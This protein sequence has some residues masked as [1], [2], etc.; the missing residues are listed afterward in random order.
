MFWA[1]HTSSNPTSGEFGLPTSTERAFYVKVAVPMRL[2]DAGRLHWP[3][4]RE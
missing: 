3:A 1:Q 4:S 2:L